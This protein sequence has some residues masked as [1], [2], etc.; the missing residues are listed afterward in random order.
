MPEPH[1][2]PHA[3]GYAVNWLLR[4]VIWAPFILTALTSEI[5]LFVFVRVCVNA[6]NKVFMNSI[7]R[8]S[9][10]RTNYFHRTLAN[11]APFPNPIDSMV[12]KC[13]IC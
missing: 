5:T 10:A 7:C 12:L 9:G 8:A 11:A 13:S 3:A 2:T 6:V 4:S 1:S